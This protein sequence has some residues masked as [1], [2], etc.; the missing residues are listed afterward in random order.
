MSCE[1]DYQRT[2]GGF[3]KATHVHAID[4]HQMNPEFPRGDYF[5]NSHK[6][7][8]V[9]NS[10]ISG[11]GKSTLGAKIARENLKKFRFNFFFDPELQWAEWMRGYP[12]RSLDEA[13]RAI[14]S[15]GVCFYCPDE[16]D[17]QQI[18][19]EKFAEWFWNFGCSFRG[20]K[21]L[22]HDE[23]NDDI[24]HSPAA[25]A[26]HP[27]QKIMGKGR[28][29]GMKYFGISPALQLLATTFRMQ[30]KQIYAFANP[31]PQ[32]AAYMVAKGI[33]ADQYA[34]L[35]PGEFIYLETMTRKTTPGKIK[36][37]S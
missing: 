6:P 35:Q 1:A 30:F 20:T 28:K 4:C 9:L 8:F 23:I 33:P 11:T 21:C 22:W 10:G 18:G 19:F 31:D 32:C 3:R 27:M 5:D 14:A 37:L 24:P 7:W 15:T 36:L 34:R 25:Y 29:R 16:F 26:A 12:C 17:S 13:A 2:A